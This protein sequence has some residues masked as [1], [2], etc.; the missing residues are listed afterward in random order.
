MSYAEFEICSRIC[1]K[2]RQKELP[3]LL[4]AYG[5]A[6][7][8]T[9]SCT[10]T[11]EL[12]INVYRKKIVFGNGDI[13]F[14]QWNELVPNLDAVCNRVIDIWEQSADKPFT[15]DRFPASQSDEIQIHPKDRTLFDALPNDYFTPCEI[16]NIEQY[17]AQQIQS[18]ARNGLAKRDLNLAF[19]FAIRNGTS[20][21]S[22]K[23]LYDR[24]L[25]NYE[26]LE[27]FH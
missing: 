11:K 14:T 20:A 16:I 24:I 5:N 1:Q 4:Q 12:V 23:K 17:L 13:F 22:I 6:L 18:F 19:A 27:T 8:V 10:I 2:L 26:A 9:V 25:W 7:G 21:Q 3:V 15:V